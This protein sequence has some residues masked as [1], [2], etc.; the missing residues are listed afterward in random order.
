MYVGSFIA[1]ATGDT[2][3]LALLF[4]RSG[5]CACWPSRGYQVVTVWDDKAAV[6]DKN[7]AAGLHWGMSLSVLALTEPSYLP[8]A[9]TVVFI[10]GLRPVCS[11]YSSQSSLLTT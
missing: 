1:A 8:I 2:L 7:V 9:V 11:L 5:S 6:Q 4:L 10:F 3:P